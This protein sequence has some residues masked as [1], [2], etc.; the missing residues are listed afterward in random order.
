[1]LR[2][3]VTT[4]LNGYD[5]TALRFA[6]AGT[7]LLPVV[8][9]RGRAVKRIG[10]LK[11]LLMVVGFG[12]PY[13]LLLSLGLRTAPASAAGAL[14]P[15]AMAVAS[16]FLG[17]A[18]FGDEIGATRSIGIGLAL[19]GVALFTGFA[20]PV[21]I[22]HLILV[23]TGIM[24][25]G[26]S[27]IV[28]LVGVPALNA[29]AIIAVG[30]AIL[31]L[32]VYIIALPKQI[33]TAPMPDILTQGAFQ[34]LLVSVVAVYAFNR[35]VELLGPLAG[36]TLPALVPVA[37]LVLGVI[38]LGEAAGTAHFTAAGVIGLGVALIL[39]GRFFTNWLASSVRL[40][41]RGRH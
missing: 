29:A 27:L 19:M 8:M 23:T 4:S 3:G 13:A 38:I 22:G 33:G 41:S 39:A 21:T 5:L 40:G 7:L 15:G 10:I 35:S 28:R 14:N 6:V 17:W 32:P 36:A 20:G 37:T 25:A 31:Y 1:M 18:F 12:A 34:G 24:W 2:L 16:V 9:R 11:L 30:S 26:Y